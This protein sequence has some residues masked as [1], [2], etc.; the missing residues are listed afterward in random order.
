LRVLA[1]YAL[2]TPA[3]AMWATPDSR[4]LALSFGAVANSAAH[5]LMPLVYSEI[6]K[7]TD[8]ASFTFMVNGALA[9]VSAALF[10]L[11]ALATD[12]SAP[13][14]SENG[15]KYLDLP[16]SDQP[17][18]PSTRLAR[19]V[20]C[21]LRDDDPIFKDEEEEE[22]EQSASDD[23]YKM[24]KS[25]VRFSKQHK[26]RFSGGRTRFSRRGKLISDSIDE[27]DELDSDTEED[28]LHGDQSLMRKSTFVGVDF[29]RARQKRAA[30][31]EKL[32]VSVGR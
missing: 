5:I 11:Q 15:A 25:M 26:N 12:P 7:L 29:A 9:F 21:C 14:P 32:R 31:R 3:L 27:D 24:R 13:P 23:I 1:D 28:F 2:G 19:A 22:E 18:H 16:E 10:G 4:G 20:L 17:V 6:L 8:S 30:T